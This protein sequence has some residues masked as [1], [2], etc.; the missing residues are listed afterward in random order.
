MRH[1]FA[2][3]ALVLTALPSLADPAT[4]EQ[5]NDWIA[6]LSADDAAKRDEAQARIEALDLT[7]K[8]TLRDALAKATDAEARARLSTILEKLGR[9]LWITDIGTALA[10]SRAENKPLLVLATPGTP[11]GYS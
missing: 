8:A 6:Q 2:V 7:W 4:P 1:L 11:D 3:L 10:K 9:P 5:V